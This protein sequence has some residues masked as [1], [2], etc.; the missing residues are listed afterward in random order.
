[1][2]PLP[3]G[4]VLCSRY[5]ISK[6][7]YQSKLANVYTVEDTHLV[8][9]IWAVK[10]MKV[11]ALN[12]VE[13][14]RIIAHFQAEV[15]KM[16]EL[17]HPNMAR[18]IDFFVEGRNLYIIREFIPAYDIET[19]MAKAQG[20]LRERDCLAWGIQL[21][22]CLSYLNAKK[23]PAIFY[24]ELALSNILVNSEGMIKIIDLGLARLFQTETNPEKM[25]SM[26]SM[27]YAPPEQF[28]E[29]GSFDQRS[30]VYSCGAMIYHMLTGQNPSLSMFNLQ[31][32]DEVNPEV[33]RAT[34]AIIKKAT[35][36]EPRLRHQTLPEL[37]KDLQRARKDPESNPVVVSIPENERPTG[38][39]I[40]LIVF[41]SAFFGLA[42]AAVIV[43]FIYKFLF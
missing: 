40:G 30:L 2:G 6:I 22:D 43:Y 26:G 29:Y 4:S 31:S 25:Q 28:D 37:K 10:E 8:G 35:S 36:N 39:N 13:R 1:M 41:L 34:C 27:H 3:V 12:N 9:N 38:Q 14:Q 32:I 24:R 33:S 7:L 5:R 15:M 16:T 18:V 19:L 20:P 11:L 23:F 42:A 17:T 21:A